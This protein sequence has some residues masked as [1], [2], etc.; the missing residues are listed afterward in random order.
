MK[1]RIYMKKFTKMF[2][3][4]GA[5][6]SMIAGL[7]T[8]PTI[9]ANATLIIP[10]DANRDN[11]VTIADAIQVMLYLYGTTSAQ[12]N[13]RFTCMDANN[14]GVIDY[15]DVAQIQYMEAHSLTGLPVDKTL[16]TMPNESAVTYCRHTCDSGNYTNEYRYDISSLPVPNSL[17]ST[18]DIMQLKEKTDNVKS[19]SNPSVATVTSV[20][21]GYAYMGNGFIVSNHII[22]TSANL[23]Y[24]INYDEYADEVI[25]TI[26]NNVF[27]GETIHVPYSYTLLP[28]NSTDITYDYALIYVEDDLSSYDEWDLGVASDYFAT[29]GSSLTTKGSYFSHNG[30]VSTN[31]TAYEIHSSADYENGGA[32]YYESLFNGIYKKSVIGICSNYSSYT[33]AVKITPAILRF[34]KQNT[35]LT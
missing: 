14:D 2:T 30:Y 20:F 19:A 10:G 6:V 4:I 27:Y 3:T 7:V 28:N 31:S 1:G 16:Y 5:T 33:K 8:V 35:Y 23:L 24:N 29:T 32:V 9:N 25:V 26:D 21:D 12:S 11:S 15:N 17:Y 13:L 18:S 22:A 34:Y